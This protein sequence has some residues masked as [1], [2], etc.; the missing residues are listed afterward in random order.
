[1]NQ[2]KIL[3]VEDNWE[4]RELLKV[5]LTEKGFDVQETETGQ[6]AIDACEDH[7]PDL[8]VLDLTLPDIDG[9]EVCKRVRAFP[10]MTT[11]PIIICS[12]RTTVHERVTGLETDAGA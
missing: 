6:D 10:A 11:A 7:T 9:L 4:I 12:G 1:M 2:P 5:I 3:I 8:V